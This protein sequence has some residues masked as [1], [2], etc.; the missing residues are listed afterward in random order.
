[1]VFRH[2]A[3]LRI[4][5]KVKIPGAVLRDGICRTGNHS[6]SASQLKKKAPLSLAEEEDLTAPASDEVP[7]QTANLKVKPKAKVAAPT[8]EK[9]EQPVAQLP[10]ARSAESALAAE[11]Q[12]HFELWSQDRTA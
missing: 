4:G 5:Q 6:E 7:A 1:M 10:S 11:G 2:D 12:G 3:N 9:I 8:E